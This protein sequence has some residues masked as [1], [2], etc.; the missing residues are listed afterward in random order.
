MLRSR[1]QQEYNSVL[2]NALNR[3]FK[4][5]LSFNNFKWLLTKLV[6]SCVR[7]VIPRSRKRLWNGYPV[8]NQELQNHDP[9][10]RHIPVFSACTVTQWKIKMQTIQYRRTRIWEM[11][12]DEYTKTLAKLQVCE[13]FQMRDIG[14]NG[15]P[16]FIKLCMETPC[17]CPFLEHQYGRRIP[18]ETSVFEFSY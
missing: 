13:I 5:N 12:K 1:V 4:S 15:L 8:L 2:V 10:G 16:K 9:V 14:K 11:K 17:W 7:N 18:T 3:I 6:P